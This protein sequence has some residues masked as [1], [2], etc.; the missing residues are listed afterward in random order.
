MCIAVYVTA[1]N[2]HVIPPIMLFLAHYSDK[3]QEELVRS[4]TKVG[5]RTNG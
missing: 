4:M 3:E 2:K 1:E 5:G